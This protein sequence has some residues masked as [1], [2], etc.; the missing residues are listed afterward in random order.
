MYLKILI[1]TVI[2]IIA[3]DLKA[4]EKVI[5][6]YK[7]YEKF[8]LS[9]LEVE[10]KIIAPGDLSVRQRTRRR[11]KRELYIRK[12]FIDTIKKEINYQR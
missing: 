8:D 1:S 3:Q 6:E 7:Q 11:V 5:Y 9:N 12:D 2:F 4:E 10:G